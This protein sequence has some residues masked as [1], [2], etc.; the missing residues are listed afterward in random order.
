MEDEEGGWCVSRRGMEILM[1]QVLQL[2]NHPAVLYLHIWIPG[3]NM[4]QFWGATIEDEIE[5]L[6]KY[7]G[8]QSISLRNA[9]YDKYIDDKV[10]YREAD[11]ACNIVHP[12]YLYHRCGPTPPTSDPHTK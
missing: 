1:R 11:I 3:F 12:N 4:G 5:V 10:G 6:V 2:P 9:L 7:Y 8:I